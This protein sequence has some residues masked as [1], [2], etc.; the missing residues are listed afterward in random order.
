MLAGNR[1]NLAQV[2]VLVY[3]ISAGEGES[4]DKTSIHLNGSVLE[5]ERPNRGQWSTVLAGEN[6][7]V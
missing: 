7:S 1:L 6:N 3:V 2:Y 5:L 4:N